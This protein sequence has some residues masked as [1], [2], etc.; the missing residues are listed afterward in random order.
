MLEDR[1]NVTRKTTCV[2][3]KVNIL[4]SWLTLS[5]AKAVITKL[6]DPSAKG[7]K[8]VVTAPRITL[9]SLIFLAGGES[10][11]KACMPIA[12][13]GLKDNKLTVSAR[14]VPMAMSLKGRSK[15]LLPEGPSTNPVVGFLKRAAGSLVMAPKILVIPGKIV[16]EFAIKMPA[17]TIKKR[18]L[19][20]KD[21]DGD[22]PSV[23]ISLNKDGLIWEKKVGFRLP[24]SICIEKCKTANPAKLY[25]QGELGMALSS[26][27]TVVYGSL[28][29]ARPWYA[30][31]VPFLHVL[32]GRLMLGVDLK[33]LLPSRMELGAMSCVGSKAACGKDAQGDFI[34]GSVFAGLDVTNPAKNYAVVMLTECSIG[35]LL[36]ALLHLLLISHRDSW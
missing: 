14:M 22:G 10:V 24:L 17:I 27:A 15:L 19:W 8:M 31:V 34:K 18:S 36:G 13:I 30:A 29:M 28:Q 26:T 16:V 5:P 2:R 4:H 25:F 7:A 9:G 35:K 20:L 3:S 32:Y 33:T 11:L 23:F 21:I 6:P 12:G 1:T